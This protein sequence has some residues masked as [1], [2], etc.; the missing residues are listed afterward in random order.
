MEYSM[1]EKHG[2]KSEWIKEYIEVLENAN[3]ATHNLIIMR[4]DRIL[5][6]HY[7]NP[8]NKDFLHR[9]YS[10]TKSFV[11]LAIG[12]LEQDGK[13][14]LDDPIVKYFPEELKDNHDEN[15]RNQTIRQMLMMAT[16]KECWGWFQARPDDRVEH[17][18]K[19]NKTSRPAG[20]IFSYDSSGSFVL[21]A[22]VERI[23]GKSFMEYSREKYLDKIGF[24]KEAYMLKCPGGHSWGDSALICT[25]IDL[26]KAAMFC[27]HKGKW[28]GEQLL[29]EEFIT[30]ATGKQ[31]AN[32]EL[33]TDDC[34]KQGYGY[35]FWR[36]YDNS[37]FFNGAGSQ[38]AICVPDKNIIMVYN[39]NN[40]DKS[41]A[42]KI[43]LDN[44]FNMIVRR[45]EDFAF[46]DSGYDSLCEY[47]KSLKLLSAK[48][49][50]TAEIANK[51]NGVTY[52]MDE[53][54]MGITRMKLT[55]NGKK[56]IL[57]Y[58]NEQGDKEIPF[59]MCE[60][61]FSFFPQKGYSDEVGG[62][63]G[64]RLYKC[65]TSAAWKSDYQLYIKVQIN[66]TYFGVLNITIGFV[67]NKIGVYMISAAEDFLTEYYGF[68]G[69]VAETY[70]M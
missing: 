58:T 4:N 8:F 55:F 47:V 7:W 34:N 61:E 30:A 28:N 40:M 31:I 67:D 25:P 44:F 17:Y 59:G 57:S 65:A 33:G 26:L 50:S 23:T 70:S 21:C 45:T 11:A 68:A 20:T 29:N 62:Q 6:E 49:K 32:D 63:P 13:I 37:Y 22:L 9:M 54:P 42:R 3:L 39:G 38:Y 24:S 2:I 1:P 66:D 43:I 5:F 10:V 41:E 12:F 52:K 35:Q 69:G 36:T 64:N 18:F 19:N 46:E 51:I 14:S 53:N 27:M 16:A 56:G 15:V 60:N 48:G